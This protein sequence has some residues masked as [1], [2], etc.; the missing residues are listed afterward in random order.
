L[1]AAIAAPVT[2]QIKSKAII[3]DTHFFTIILVS[4][5]FF[6]WLSWKNLP[7]ALVFGHPG[8]QGASQINLR[9]AHPLS[10]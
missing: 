4:W 7:P 8:G 9:F 3:A 2:E 10:T 1:S 5:L 6:C